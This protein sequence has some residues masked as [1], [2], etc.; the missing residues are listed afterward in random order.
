[1]KL[2]RGCISEENVPF[3]AANQG[4]PC[5]YKLTLQKLCQ[6]L[7]VYTRWGVLQLDIIIGLYY[8]LGLH[9]WSSKYTSSCHSMQVFVLNYMVI[10]LLFKSRNRNLPSCQGLCSRRR[11]LMII[12]DWSNEWL[13]TLVLFSASPP[14]F[15]LCG[16][17]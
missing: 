10:F 7:S 12:T 2:N 1:M 5:F 13:K 14:W 17:L 8:I 9:F 4:L 3:N 11:G 16:L 6:H 15:L